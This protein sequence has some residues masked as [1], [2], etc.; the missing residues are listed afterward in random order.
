MA[1]VYL[2]IGSNIQRQHYISRCLDRLYGEF[3]EL[4]ISSIYESEAVGFDA[5]PFFNLVTGLDTDLSLSDLYRRLRA[6]EHDNGRDI[7]AL[8]FSSRTLDIDILTYDDYVGSFEGGR[9][10]REDITKNAFVLWPMAELEP[11]SLHPEEKI[12]YH[13][14]WQAFDRSQQVLRPVP[15]IW[16]GR[17]LSALAES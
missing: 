1:R 15:F 11:N 17:Q 13:Q 12:S 16:R 2:S 7:N 10:P 4:L 14:L 5:E 8:K 9:L 6:I 3:G